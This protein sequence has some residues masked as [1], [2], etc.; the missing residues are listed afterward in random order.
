M[1]RYDVDYSKICDIENIKLA[2]KKASK[3]KT[4]KHIVRKVLANIDYYSIQIQNLLIN[5]SYIPSPYIEKVIYEGSSRKERI[6]HKP[7]FYPDQI[8]HHCLMNILEPYIS[9]RMYYYSCASI[10]GKGIHFGVKYIQKIYKENSSNKNK[11]KIKYCL[12]LDIRKFYPSI[13]TSIL[14]YKFSR[15]VKNKDTL[16]LINTIIDSHDKGLPIGNYTSQWF[17]NFYLTDLDMFILHNIKPYKYIRYADDMVLLGGN[18]RKLHKALKQIKEYLYRIDNLEL[19]N[20]Y[21][22]F[23]LCNRPLDFLGYKYYPKVNTRYPKI[24][25]ITTIRGS[26]FLRIK[27][28]LNRLVK[29]QYLNHHNASS[30]ISYNGWIKYSNYVNFYNRYINNKILKF[31]KLKEIIKH[32]VRL[33]RCNAYTKICCRA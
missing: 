26:I 21:Q 14:K 12:K 29:K 27:R 20:N 3:G 31:K 13:D 22:V 28:C 15:M 33:H 1:K 30:I 18:K 32:Y 11:H 23:R 16:W 5:K 24:R 6:I 4:R 25:L 9:K 8:I 17:S 7:Q 2:I 19:K 10:K